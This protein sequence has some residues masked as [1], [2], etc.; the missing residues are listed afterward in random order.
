MC[1][2]G[3]HPSFLYI[4][5]FGYTICLHL[6]LLGDGHLY[7]LGD[8]FGEGDYFFSIFDGELVMDSSGHSHARHISYYH[9]EQ[10][11]RH[12]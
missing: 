1:N 10:Q 2:H 11:T 4:A 6:Y 8:C 7:L 3:I 12:R 5:S 9:P